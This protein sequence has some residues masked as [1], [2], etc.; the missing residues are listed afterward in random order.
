MKHTLLV[1][2]IAASFGVKGQVIDIHAKPVRL[3]PGALN[4][5]YNYES[6][7]SGAYKGL[8]A[9]YKTE[10]KTYCDTFML[11]V[12]PSALGR[13]FTCGN[14]FYL[15]DNNRRIEISQ[16]LAELLIKSYRQPAKRNK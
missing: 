5:M 10:S 4:S 2:L 7:Q 3:K 13:I 16:Q 14:Q 11:K 6:S 15:Q 9:Q 12:Q 8:I 1:I